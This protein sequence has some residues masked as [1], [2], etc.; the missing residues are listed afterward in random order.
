MRRGA[1]RPRFRPVGRLRRVVCDDRDALCGERRGSGAPRARQPEDE[2]ASREVAHGTSV[3]G[4]SPVKSDGLEADAPEAGSVPVSM[5]TRR[6]HLLIAAA[7]AGV[8]VAAAIAVVAVTG[9]KEEAPEVSWAP[10]PRQVRGLTVLAQAGG[11][12]RPAHDA[13]R[14]RLPSRSASGRRPRGISL[15][16]WRSPQPTTAAGSPR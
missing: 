4:P 6:R 7:L 14:R 3:I 9:G 5:R 16:S 11:T 2:D 10:A 1:P 12:L 8:A 15:A 13:R